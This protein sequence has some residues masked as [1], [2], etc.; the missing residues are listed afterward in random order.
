MQS[1][2]DNAPTSTGRMRRFVACTRCRQ[3]KIKCVST[4]ASKIPDT[5]CERCAR[6]KFLCSYVSVAEQYTHAHRILPVRY[7][8]SATPP[9]TFTRIPCSLARAGGWPSMPSD[10]QQYLGIGLVQPELLMPTPA[11]FHPA[12][13]QSDWASPYTAASTLFNY[14]DFKFDFTHGQY[15]IDYDPY[16][17]V[18]ATNH[19]SYPPTSI[20]HPMDYP[21]VAPEKCLDELDLALL[22]FGFNH[23]TVYAGPCVCPPGLCFCGLSD[24][25]S[26]APSASGTFFG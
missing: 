10:G 24:S 14:G 13:S 4:S 18:N 16:T 5:A 26:P 8:P 25:V 17:D 19:T 23:P 11:F 20:P 2:L 3:R 15:P 22:G 21:F 6:K 9:E 1:Q 12:S 7:A